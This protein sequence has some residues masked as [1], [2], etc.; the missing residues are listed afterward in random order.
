MLSNIKVV[1]SMLIANIYLPAKFNFV[2]PVA[3]EASFNLILGNMPLCTS[4]CMHD[5]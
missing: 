2:V 1:V 5:L 3:V 4:S